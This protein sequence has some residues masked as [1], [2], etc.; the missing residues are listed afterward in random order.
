MKQMKQRLQRVNILQQFEIAAKSDPEMQQLLDSF[1][2][3]TKT[4]ELA[5]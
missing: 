4:K 5:K 1:H 2:S 3:C